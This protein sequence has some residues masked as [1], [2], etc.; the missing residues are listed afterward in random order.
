MSYLQFK[1]AKNTTHLGISEAKYFNKV[2]MQ[3]AQKSFR[4][5][6]RTHKGQVHANP[7]ESCEYMV[8]TKMET[9]AKQ[10]QQLVYIYFQAVIT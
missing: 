6:F 9:L 8:R 10:S 1:L 5:Y 7:Q 2:E 4:T 3:K